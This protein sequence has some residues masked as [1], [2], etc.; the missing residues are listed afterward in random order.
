LNLDWSQIRSFV[1]VAQEG[2]L[3]RA[4][5]RLGLS[6]PTVGRHVRRLEK[7]IGETLFVR[8]PEGLVL[9]DRGRVLMEHA[10][11]M[12][13]AAFA[14]ESTAQ[15]SDH[16]LAGVVR[17]AT[18]EVFGSEVVPPLLGEL[19]RTNPA[20]EIELVVGD[21]E[22]NLLRR[23]ADVAVRHF[24][25][26]QEG[27]ICRQVG[28]VAVGLYA[29]RS[30]LESYGMP[31]GLEDAHEHTLVG[32][33][34]RDIGLRAARRIGMEASRRDFRIRSDSIRTQM[35]LITAGLGLGSFQVSLA[36]RCPDLVRVLPELEIE[37]LEVWVVAHDEVRRS[38]RVR[39]VFDALL[40]GLRQWIAGSAPSSAST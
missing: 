28:S 37:S 17:I 25:P 40:E 15:A 10:E 36:E 21:E 7:Q 8:L 20:L 19:T 39:V 35:A 38:R 13:S 16:E 33:D 14:L 30:Y 5:Q 26:D 29:A 3:T 12:Q 23:R 9:T 31:R 1:A 6:Q 2:S 4:A 27:L 22:A 32:F 11:V 24:R 34:Q 18:S